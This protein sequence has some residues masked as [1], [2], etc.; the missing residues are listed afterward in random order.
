MVFLF[1]GLEDILG[2]SHSE[3]NP[4]KIL[5]NKMQ[6]RGQSQ[7]ST[8][9]KSSHSQEFLFTLKSLTSVSLLLSTQPAVP[10]PMMMKSYSGNTAVASG[11]SPLYSSV[12]SLRKPSR[13][14]KKEGCAEL[15]VSVDRMI[16]KMFTSTVR[17]FKGLYTDVKF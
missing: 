7:A 8:K 4:Y 11:G 6:D 5:T 12:A 13:A 16:L 3:S 10:A 1:V 14:S 2:S 15:R 9:K 17:K